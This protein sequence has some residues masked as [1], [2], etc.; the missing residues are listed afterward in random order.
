MLQSLSARLQDGIRFFFIP[1]PQLQ[2]RPLRFDCPEN[3]AK[4]WAYRVPRHEYVNDLGSIYPPAGVIGRV[5]SEKKSLTYPLTFWFKR[6]SSLRL[7]YLTVFIDD[8][9]LLA[10]S[11]CPM[12][13]SALLLADSAS[14][15][16]LA[17]RF[18]RV[19]FRH[20]SNRIISYSAG[21]GGAS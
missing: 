1:Y 19:R 18:L 21:V 4:L 14:P 6:T 7:L 8:S 2:G 5:G 20:A 13:L 10:L 11:L 15:H 9:H 16:G 12:P 3:R 17:Y